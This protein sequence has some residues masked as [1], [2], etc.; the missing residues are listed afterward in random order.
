MITTCSAFVSGE[1]CACFKTSVKR[2]PL[3]NK[4]C[5]EASKSDPN[6]AKA[7]ISLYCANSNFTEPATDFIAFVCA[8]DPT[9]DTERPVFT[10]GLIP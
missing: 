3:F 9:L 4:A 7:A 8:D 5:V 6:C 2:A 10:A 1:Y